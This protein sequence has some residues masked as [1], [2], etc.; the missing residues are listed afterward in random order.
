MGCFLS[1][2]FFIFHC[3]CLDRGATSMSQP[4]LGYPLK[5]CQLSLALW[6]KQC[7][8][9][10]RPL[11]TALFLWPSS[12]LLGSP[13]ICASYPAVLLEARSSQR[14]IVEWGMHCRHNLSCVKRTNYQSWVKARIQLNTS[15]EPHVCTLALWIKW[16]SSLYIDNQRDYFPP[17][18]ILYQEWDRLCK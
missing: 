9:V 3:F 1:C 5:Q 18:Y 11:Q 12:A 13:S 16:Y 10:N 17:T 15:N 7:V 4:Q 14:L 6:F 2:P 8:S